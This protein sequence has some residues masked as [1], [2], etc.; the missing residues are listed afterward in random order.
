MENK[1]KLRACPFCGGKAEFIDEDFEG[2]M[3]IRCIECAATIPVAWGESKETIIEQWN[4][5]EI[6][7]RAV[8]V[9]DD[10]T[11]TTK[12]KALM[13]YKLIKRYNKYY[14]KKEK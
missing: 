12:E 6:L 13:F 14:D 7:D 10:K 1:V 11:L 4:T 3:I 8:D 2:P 5:R 9:S